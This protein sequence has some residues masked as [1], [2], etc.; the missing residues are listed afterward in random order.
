MD[1]DVDVVVRRVNGGVAE[2]GLGVECWFRKKGA[3]TYVI[4]DGNRNTV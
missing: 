4:F 1:V 2:W 3:P